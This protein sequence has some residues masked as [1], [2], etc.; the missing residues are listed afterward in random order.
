MKR[1]GS[2]SRLILESGWT[3]D[4]HGEMRPVYFD[5][6]LTLLWTLESGREVI[7]GS[8]SEGF[9]T[10]SFVDFGNSVAFGRPL[11]Q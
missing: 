11:K 8:A 4:N 7:G 10:F 2:D 5:Q 6:D 9:S 3:L 1:T